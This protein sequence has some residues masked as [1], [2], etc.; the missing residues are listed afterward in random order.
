[1]QHDVNT[2]P[3]SSILTADIEGLLNFFDQKPDWS[4]GHATG[5]VAVVGE[6]LNAACLQHYVKCRGG[7]TTVLRHPITG[8]PFAVT[9]GHTKGPRLDRWIKLQWPDR[10][11]IVFQTEIKNWSAHAFGSVPFPLSGSLREV[12]RRKRE[13]WDSL[14]DSRKKRLK[15]PLTEKVLVPMRPPD[16]VDH[17]VEVLPLLI[18]WAAVESRKKPNDHLFQVDVA[19]A[20]FKKLWVFSVSGYLR[21]LRSEGVA[22]IELEMPDAARRLWSLNR[23]FSS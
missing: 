18:F 13:Q 20:E 6:D 15:N 19:G 22:S 16:C 10:S 21:S 3:S 2:V 23:L 17:G 8:K 4:V 7:S 5:I 1:M 14:W 12:R 9:T 11:A